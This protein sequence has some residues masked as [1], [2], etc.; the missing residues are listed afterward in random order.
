MTPP[1]ILYRGEV[2]HVRLR[3]RQH[4]LAYRVFALGLDVDRIDEAAAGLRLFRRNRLGLLSFHDRDHGDPALAG[5]VPVAEQIRS[6]LAAAGWAT[7][8]ARIELICYPRLWGYVFNPLSVYLCHDEADRLQAVAY[9]VNNTFGERTS[10]IVEAEGNEGWA[11]SGCR[12]LMYV[13]PFTPAQG[14]YG[15]ALRRDA[16]GMT[17][18]VRLH[19][20]D[21]ALLR[22][23]FRA[24]AEPA[25]DARLAAAVARHPLM[26][27]KVIAAIHYEAAKLFFKGVPVVQRH[28]SPRFS[29]RGERARHSG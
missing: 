13:S 25:T 7:A 9:E 11:V 6:S 1:L 27:F 12:K 24:T 4:R 5:G 8:G 26:T 19:D 23:H 10:Y 29:V 2:V 14:R 20:R 17:L 3:P 15:F 18:G 21:G 22:T 28:A 16:T